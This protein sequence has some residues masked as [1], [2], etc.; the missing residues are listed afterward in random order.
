MPGTG[1]EGWDVDREV[2]W[3]TVHDGYNMM[4]S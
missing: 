4:H 1:I 2:G 3:A